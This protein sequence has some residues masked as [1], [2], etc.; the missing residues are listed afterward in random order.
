MELRTSPHT[1]QTTSAII[2]TA[3]FDAKK[4][5]QNV[6]ALAK[7]FEYYTSFCLHLSVTQAQ[8]LH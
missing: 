7:R 6:L 3:D 4:D 5:W 1:R 8:V 2:L